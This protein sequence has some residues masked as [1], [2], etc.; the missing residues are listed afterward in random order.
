MKYTTLPNTDLNISKFCLGTM[1]WGEQN[2]GT[3]AHEQPNFDYLHSV[4]GY[5][6][7]ILPKTQNT[8][9]LFTSKI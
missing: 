1:T 8:I 7:T 3:Q 2:T 5:K 4:I 6:D 9:Y